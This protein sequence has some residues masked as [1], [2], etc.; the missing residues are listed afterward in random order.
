MGWTW[1]PTPVLMGVMVPVV[2]LMRVVGGD[3]AG[4]ELAPH[5]VDPR[6]VLQRDRPSQDPKWL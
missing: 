5:R 1:V 4:T 6:A 2:A 3:A